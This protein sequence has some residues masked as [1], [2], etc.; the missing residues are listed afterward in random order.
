MNK[1]GC[2]FIGQIAR[3]Q[4]T[5]SEDDVA[6]WGV[7]TKDFNF[8]YKQGFPKKDI[9]Q[10]IIPGILSEGLIS[11]VIYKELPGTPCVIM[12][13]ELLFIHPVYIGNTVTVEVEIIEVNHKQNWIIEKVRCINERGID[14]IKGKIILKLLS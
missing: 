14:V 5:F 12:Q 1:V 11:E 6:Q 7:L 8:V 13:K 10:P 2:Y 9:C 3:M 4:R